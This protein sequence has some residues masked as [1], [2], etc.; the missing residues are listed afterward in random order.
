MLSCRGSDDGCPPLLCVV[1]CSSMC[2]SVVGLCGVLLCAWFVD[3]HARS[4][5]CQASRPRLVS[6]RE[7]EEME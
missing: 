2:S 4:E 6:V 5:C 7:F 3:C 1:L